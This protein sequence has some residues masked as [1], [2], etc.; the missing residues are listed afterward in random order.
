MQLCECGIRV[1][2]SNSSLQETILMIRCPQKVYHTAVWRDFLAFGDI[3]SISS[4]VAPSDE[5]RSRFVSHFVGFSHVS[6]D[7]VTLC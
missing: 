5:G 3:R 4:L 6:H 1:S 2:L 7:E